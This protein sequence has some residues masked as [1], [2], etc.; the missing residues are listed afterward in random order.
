LNIKVES[1]LITALGY[2]VEAANSG[3]EAI[4]MVQNTKYDLIFMDI[5]MPMMDGVKTLHELN[6]LD[7]FDTKVIALTADAVL[8]AKDRYLS[9]GFDEYITKPMS[10]EE[11]DKVIKKHL[12]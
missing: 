3:I 5:M 2:D 11:F 7:G 6:K 9:E 10:K 12:K 8:G 4:K 1:K